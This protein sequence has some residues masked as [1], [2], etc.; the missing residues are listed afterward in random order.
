VEKIQAEAYKYNFYVPP[1][2]WSNYGGKTLF[3]FGVK[4]RLQLAPR[5]A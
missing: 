5:T 3:N 4:N 1:D 2:G